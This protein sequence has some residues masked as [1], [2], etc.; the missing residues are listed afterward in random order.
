ML[1]GGA[2]F[3]RSFGPHSAWGSIE[4]TTILTTHPSL[5]YSG[6]LSQLRVR[7][8]L[9]PM[10]SNVNISSTD[11]HR[12]ISCSSLSV[13]NAEFY[14]IKILTNQILILL[15]GSFFE[16]STSFADLIGRILDGHIG[17]RIWQFSFPSQ[18]Y[19]SLITESSIFSGIRESAFDISQLK[20]NRKIKIDTTCFY[21]TEKRVYDSVA[22]K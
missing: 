22:D 10:L 2:S 11:H 14:K 1:N 6:R 16:N 4:S 7:K 5:Y 12:F 20:K 19:F 21:C 15:P 3:R 9:K 8:Y 17:H 18:T 13:V